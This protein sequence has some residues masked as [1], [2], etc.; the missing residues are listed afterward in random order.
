MLEAFLALRADGDMVGETTR[1]KLIVG[2]AKELK[3]PYE[4]I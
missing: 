1:G 3:E 2:K 4:S